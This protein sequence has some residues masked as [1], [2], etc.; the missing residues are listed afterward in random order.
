MEWSR[1]GDFEKV[2]LMKGLGVNLN[3]RHCWAHSLIAAAREGYVQIVEFLLEEGADPNQ[4]N[5]FVSPHLGQLL[6]M[7]TKRWLFSACCV[8]CVF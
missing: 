3:G 2:Q 1:K 6:N 4:A 5:D 7:G 8:Q